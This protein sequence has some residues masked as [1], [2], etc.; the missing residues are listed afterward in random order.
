MFRHDLITLEREQR[1]GFALCFH[2]LMFLYHDQTLEFMFHI[3][4]LKV[5]NY[6]C[7]Q[8]PTGLLVSVKC[9]HL[10]TLWNTG[11]IVSPYFHLV[12]GQTPPDK[13]SPRTKSSHYIP[14]NCSIAQYFL[15][16]INVIFEGQFFSTFVRCDIFH[17][18]KWR[19]IAER[20]RWLK[21]V[22]SED[23]NS[24]SDAFHLC[25]YFVWILK[26]WGNRNV[27]CLSLIGCYRLRV[28]WGSHWLEKFGAKFWRDFLAPFFKHT[29]RDRN[30]HSSVVRHFLLILTK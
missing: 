23:L 11:A 10:D 25:H 28:H 15:L 17:G 24:E 13:I 19:S 26:Q 3:L 7:V 2:F 21:Y 14:P 1:L 16:Y 20:S 8:W 9:M 27:C 12:L 5:I 30:L 18:D 29:M 22:R 4:L 6:S